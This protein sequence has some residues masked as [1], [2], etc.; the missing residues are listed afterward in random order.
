MKEGHFK[1]FTPCARV[2]E[3]TRVP[4]T[5][6]PDTPHQVPV[7]CMVPTST[8]CKHV[9]YQVPDYVLDES[10][11]LLQHVEKLCIGILCWKGV[12]LLPI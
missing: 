2:Q 5:R 7:P 8:V 12:L 10:S 6:V 4:G 3:S 9:L 11:L 1:K